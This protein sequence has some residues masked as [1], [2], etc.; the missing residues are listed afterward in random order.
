MSMNR[1]GR[2]S[3]IEQSSSDQAG[4]VTFSGNKA[5]QIEE[6]VLFDLG[7]TQT[8]G[9]DFADVMPFKNRLNGMERADEFGLAGLSEPENHAPL[10]APVTKEL[11]H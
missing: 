1:Q 10:C 4:G 11:Q 2:K 3:S 5:L 7:D 6:P 9:V 8:T